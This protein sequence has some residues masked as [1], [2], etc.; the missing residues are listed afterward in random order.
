MQTGASRRIRRDAS[1]D[2]RLPGVQQRPNEV[3]R[4][5]VGDADDGDHRHDPEHD[6]AV[7]D[8]HAVAQARS[9]DAERDGA[10]ARADVHRRPVPTEARRNAG[11]RQVHLDARRDADR[12]AE[13]HA[14]QE[15]HDRKSSAAV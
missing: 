10:A 11:L 5:Q 1:E 9:R 15:C 6:G 12:L 3:G 8:R 4:D 7:R 14:F 2:L 13:P